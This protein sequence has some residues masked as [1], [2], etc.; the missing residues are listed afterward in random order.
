[1]S[2]PADP[3]ASRLA[4]ADTDDSRLATAW[5]A[6]RIIGPVHRPALGTV[7][8]ALLGPP[9]VATVLM[10]WLLSRWKLEEPFF[11]W[12]P[13]RWLGAAALGSG[14]LLAADS[15]TRFSRVGRGTPAPWASPTTFVATGLYRLV[16]NPM[17]VGVLL[18]IVGEALV[19]GSAA[20][21]V[22]AA[23]LAIVFHLFVV[24]IEE[25]SLRA[26]FGS[27]YDD[28]CQRVGRWLPRLR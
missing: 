26:R 6:Q 9:V 16:R 12:G 8:F 22:W 1:V 19:L 3:A 4:P 20:V 13:W 5:L 17:Y 7:L 27:E 2:V 18:V 15:M 23:I 24:F 25:P 14:A 11:G 10:P 28:Y 21:L